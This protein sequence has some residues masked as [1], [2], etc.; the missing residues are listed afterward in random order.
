MRMYQSH[1][2]SLSYNILVFFEFSYKSKNIPIMKLKESKKLYIWQLKYKFYSIVHIINMGE[3]NYC[4]FKYEI[5][6][7]K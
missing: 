2:L 7:L 4:S 5:L 3:E 1:F 6:N